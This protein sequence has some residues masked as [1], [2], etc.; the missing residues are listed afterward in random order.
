MYMNLYR[1]RVNRDDK[2]KDMQFQRIIFLGINIYRLRIRTDIN[3]LF[4]NLNVSCDDTLMFVYLM[5]VV[6]IIIQTLN[7]SLDSPFT[8]LLLCL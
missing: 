1:Y 2:Y 4:L 5:L 8:K 3:N 6:F 7:S